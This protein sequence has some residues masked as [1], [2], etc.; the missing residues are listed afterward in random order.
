MSRSSAA[1]SA[2]R[3]R[4]SERSAAPPR[5][6][7]V[8]GPAAPPRRDPNARVSAP[9][10]PPRRDPDAP[11]SNKRQ[12]RASI[13]ASALAYAD[14]AIAVPR[15]RPYTPPRRRTAPGPV[16]P[17]RLAYGGVAIAERVACVALDVSGSRAMD[18]L[19]RGRVWIGVIAF[20][21]IG[22][23]AMQVS[24]LKL[25]SGIGRAVTT[26]ST[27]ERSNSALRSEVSRLSAGDRIVPLAEAKGFVMPAP[28]D[29]SYLR[30]GDDRAAAQRAARTM[31]APD[32]ANAGLAGA[33]TTPGLQ[34]PDATAGTETTPVLGTS[35]TSTTTAPAS[36]TAP[37]TVAAT[38]TAQATTGNPTAG[39][40][41]PPATTGTAPAT[42]GT[43]PV[44]A[45][46]AAGGAVPE[47]VGTTP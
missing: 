40:T 38:P 32:P 20:G 14:A 39:A 8:S 34:T 9:A 26:A 4:S 17:Q 41:A 24:L 42:T 13:D 46:T 7:R 12:P 19:V 29:V 5:P 6:R 10:A 45:G 15:Q 16:R 37:G 2:G 28:A 33:V 47:Q 43:P 36:T 11:P 3:T 35:S 1:T 22:I 31:R 18:R 44:A 25:N 30:A 23:V 27:L 21:L